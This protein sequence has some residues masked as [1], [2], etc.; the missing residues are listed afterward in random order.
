M[1]VEMVG[2][3]GAGKTTL[4]N[5]NLDHVSKHF[6]ITESK[7]ASILQKIYA[8]TLYYLFIAPKLDDKKLAKKLSYRLAFRLFKPRS[9]TVFFFDSGVAQL[10]LENLLETNFKDKQAKLELLQKFGL[11][12]TVIIVSDGISA[13]IKRELTRTDRRFQFD[14]AQ[15]QKLYKNAEE[16]IEND[17]RPL[18]KHAHI[19]KPD[20]YKGFKD[21]L[22]NAQSH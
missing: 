13:V 8:K 14:E 2:L 10:I 9:A 7:H 5:N 1:W 6:E 4:I 18:F 15:L 16:S 17:F 11:S 19:V 22:T 20:D 21:I 3:P 12:D